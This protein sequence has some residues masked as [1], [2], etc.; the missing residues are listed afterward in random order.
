MLPVGN[1][2]GSLSGALAAFA[3][4]SLTTST[5]SSIVL[6]NT[7][8]SSSSLT[9][10]KMSYE[11]TVQ[12]TS[13]KK[14]ALKNRNESLLGSKEENSFTAQSIAKAKFLL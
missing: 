1:A 11:C 7:K 12:Y 10:A 14:A 6:S 3:S 13:K 8:D 9:L 5:F 4:F 2:L